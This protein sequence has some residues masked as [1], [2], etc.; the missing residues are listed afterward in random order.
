MTVEYV[1][2][3]AILVVMGA[4]QIWLRYGPWAKEQREARGG[5]A[6][7]ADCEDTVGAR[8]AADEEETVGGRVTAEE[9]IE[10]AAV[11]AGR[12]AKVWN[13]WTAIL[14]PLAIVF[15]LVL[16]VLGALGY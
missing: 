14:G 8:A 1:V 3:G 6:N 4:V 2:L 7:S 15:G 5:Q 10:A 9:P 16:V 11:T 13:T 12:S